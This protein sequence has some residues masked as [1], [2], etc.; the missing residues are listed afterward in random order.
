MGFTRPL[1]LILLLTLAYFL[2]LAWPRG[3]ATWRDRAILAL[4]ALLVLLLVFGLAGAQTVHGGDELAVVFVVDV[5]DSIGP[6][7]KA[8]ELD[9]VRQALEKM[10]ARDQAAIVLF[11]Q[12][13]L[14]ERQMSPDKQLSEVTSVPNPRGTDLAAALRLAL[15]LFPA[16][17]ARRIVVL[18]DGGVTS[19][20][21]MDAATLAVA[22]GA[23]I[24]VVPIVG[25]GGPEALLTDVS[26]PARMHQN[27]DFTLSVTVQSNEA[28]A[29]T[30]RVFAG[31]ALVAENPVTLNKGANSFAV[32]MKAGRPGFTAF[33]VQLAPARD[34]YYQNNELAAFSQV[35]GPPRVLVVDGMKD[36]RAEA[37]QLAGALTAAG[38]SARTTTPLGLPAELTSLADWATIVLVDVPARSLSPR[39]MLTLQTYVRDLG[40]GLVAVGGPQSY[41]VGGYFK[42]PLEET[43]PVEMQIKDKQ[44][45][46]PLALVFVIDKSG[47]MGESSGGAVKIELAK[48]AVLRSFELLNPTDHVGVVAFDENASWVLPIAELGD[49]DAAARVGTL[50]AGGGTDILAGLQAVANVLPSD[51]AAVKHIVLLT[52]GGASPTGIPEL[53]KK[54]HDENNITLSAV[55]V[56][57]DAAPWLQDLPPLGGGRY[58]FT[59]DPSTIPAIF[60]EETTLAARA[61]IVEEAFFPKLAA[62]S[63]TLS[64][65]T[66][67]PQLVGYVAT[68]PKPTAQTILL[69]GREDPVLAAWQ[70]GL[71]RSVAWTSDA[72]G[73]W[74]QEWVTWSDFARFWAQTVRWTIRD[75]QSQTAELTV[76][77]AGPRT[78]LVLDTQ[79]SSGQFLNGLSLTGT[80]V[81]PSLQAQEVP[82]H[83]TA[84]GRYSAEFTPGQEG[85]Y[86]VQV[87]GDPVAV[88]SGWVNPYSPEYRSL[89]GNLDSL[90]QITAVGKGRLLN[91]P[92]GAFEHTL[93]VSPTTRDIWPTL[94]TLVALLL[95]LDVAARRLV[96]GRRDLARIREAIRE[97]LPSRKRKLTSETAPRV[98]RLMDAK[99]RATIAR[100]AAPPVEAEVAPPAPTPRAEEERAPSPPPPSPAPASDT[101]TDRLLE[102]KKRARRTTQD[103]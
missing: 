66:S 82:L 101:L 74:A 92:A 20:Q 3:R 15:A 26:A 12:N 69:S 96:L 1:A 48:E 17:S 22:S 16:G 70:Y 44:R 14:V 85:A 43:L 56:G 38:L 83:Q 5:S 24:D 103:K 29:A 54:L 71:G 51:P 39:Q 11:G 30:L 61:Y 41:G 25:V 77:A 65:I 53:V 68:S 80:I 31:G 67:V 75:E 13:A 102:A 78:E 40:R 49:G 42:T 58:H 79:D 98:A 34:T 50:R 72:T 73:R 76:Q 32:P 62:A 52:D 57:D 93:P 95:P 37:T 2:W 10:T 47:S 81:G 84:P 21:T 86:L 45:M 89:G 33:R 90:R 18:G 46:P 97:R 4:R 6:S 64:G 88:T 27:E 8:T 87:T 19:G 100:R 55:G 7:G 36:G 99:E 63:P 28:M 35:A 94:L 9:F 23:Q 60:T 59:R 91:Q